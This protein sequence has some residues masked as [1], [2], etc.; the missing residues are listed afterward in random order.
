[1]RPRP[2]VMPLQ[3]LVMAEDESGTFSVPKNTYSARCLTELKL[4]CLNTS[5]A[6]AMDRILVA[7]SLPKASISARLRLKCSATLEHSM[8]AP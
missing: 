8:V 1:M 2:E 7:L 4:P 6:M 5:R 3:S